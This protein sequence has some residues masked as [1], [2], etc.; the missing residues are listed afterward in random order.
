MAVLINEVVAEVETPVPQNESESPEER[1]P[2]DKTAFEL[3]Y[4]LAVLEQR[5]QRLLVD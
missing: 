3:T 2:L 5:R 1:L 4:L